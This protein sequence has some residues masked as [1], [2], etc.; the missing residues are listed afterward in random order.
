M[1]G[2][3]WLI[4]DSIIGHW[5]LIIDCDWTLVSYY[6]L[7]LDTGVLLLTLWL[8][9]GV[10]LLTDWTHLI[11]DCDW[12]LVCLI[13]DSDFT[14]VSY[15]WLIGHVLLLT[16]IGQ[17]CLINDWL[18]TGV[19]LLTMIGHWCLIDWLDTGVLLL[20]DW[21]LVSLLTDWTLVSYYWLCDWTL[22]SYYWLSMI[23]HW[24]LRLKV[25]LIVGVRLAV[26]DWQLAVVFVD[27]YVWL[28]AVIYHL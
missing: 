5:C 14:L 13:I 17:W 19:L 28:T 3:W 15:Y 4:I 26:Y 25:W 21:T 11:I 27:W 7:W 24:Y 9:T 16:L 12:T 1:I 23:D 6:W 10:L 22:V 2:H 18:D 8:D 20:T